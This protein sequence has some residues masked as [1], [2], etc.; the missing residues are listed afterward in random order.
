[1][2]L[3]LWNGSLIL[4]SSISNF[5]TSEANVFHKHEA[6]GLWNRVEAPL[7]PSCGPLLLLLPALPRMLLYHLTPRLQNPWDCF[8]VSMVTSR[9]FLAFQVPL[10]VAFLPYLQPPSSG[11]NTAL[12]WVL[13]PLGYASESWGGQE[14]GG[15]KGSY[16]L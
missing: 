3:F 4:H 14:R 8:L 11:L 1:M 12:A 2:S 5:L 6:A 16:F 10:Q 15:P 9:P 7:P 13:L